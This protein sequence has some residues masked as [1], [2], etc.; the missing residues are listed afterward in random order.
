MTA[1]TALLSLPFTIGAL[2]MGRSR[3]VL[4]GATGVLSLAFGLYLAFQIG[5]VNGLLGGV[6]AASH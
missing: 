1:I 6:A 3:Q 2:R 4:A 5:L